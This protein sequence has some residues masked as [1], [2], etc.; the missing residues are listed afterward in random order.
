MN[1]KVPR[2]SL[3]FGIAAAVSLGGDAFAQSQRDF[4]QFNFSPPGARSLGMGAAFIGLADD[5]TASESN[6]AG[7][8]I[9]ATP[10]FSLHGRFSEF[11]Q[12]GIGVAPGLATNRVAS[13][14]YASIVY[15][16]GRIT[17]ALYFQE[18][19][20]FEI[21]KAD[22]GSGETLL[23]GLSGPPSVCPGTCSWQSRSG[24]SYRVRHLGLSLATR[25]GQRLSF[26]ASLRRTRY[27]FDSLSVISNTLQSPSSVAPYDG[28]P[29]TTYPSGTVLQRYEAKST[30]TDDR[31][32][33]NA[34]LLLNPAGRVSA[35]LVARVG[36]GVGD[37]GDSGGFDF[38]GSSS[39]TSVALR[40]P[41]P[42]SL[43]QSAFSGSGPFDR[44]LGLPDVYGGGVA[45]RPVEQWILAV[46]VA[47]VRLSQAGSFF[48]GD[49]GESSQDV[50][51]FNIGTEYV[52]PRDQNPISLRVG[53]FSEGTSFPR[54]GAKRSQ[55][56]TAGAGMVFGKRYQLDAA[57]RYR[58]QVQSETVEDRS[59]EALV[60]LIVRLP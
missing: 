23:M 11:Q 27:L 26:G 36:G 17:L 45:I 4:P 55:N 38:P 34:G 41:F 29:V 25:A 10:E 15:P 30:G 21:E 22:S 52:I 33:F 13:P 35:G 47:R 54:I 5:A 9:L 53:F 2:W 44:R 3:T 16:K 49:V 14:S 51:N 1:R 20:R 37:S 60:S 48:S 12:R 8:T 6:P 57:F 39:S 46:D 42:F 32:T 7:L 59:K 50:T 43:T 24:V 58:K 28:R 56:F 31:W 40:S 18:N 19:A